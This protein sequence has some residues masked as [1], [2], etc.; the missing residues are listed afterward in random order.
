M[1][2][3]EEENNTWSNKMSTTIGNAYVQILPT[4]KGI[5]G[6]LE[7]QLNPQMTKAGVSGGKSFGGGL[8]SS[9]KGGAIFAG[10]TVAVAG[11]TK[12]I[13]DSVKEGAAL[14]QSLG[15]I[16]KLYGEHSDTM[17]EQANKAYK[18]V[19]MSANQ[20]METSMQ[21]SASLLQGLG[22]DTKKAARITDMA[23]R[24]MAD[25][26]NTFGSTQESVT[27]AYRG[28]AKQNYTMLD[29]LKLGYGGTKTEM[30]RLL[31]DAE[32]LTGKKYDINNLSDVYEAIHAIQG[33]LKVTGTTSKEALGTLSGSFMA[34]KANWSNV[35]GHLALGDNKQLLQDMGNLFESIKGMTKNLVPMIG[36]ILAGLVTVVIPA[37]FMGILEG[38]QSSFVMLWGQ[39]VQGLARLWAGIKAEC[40]LS[41][42]QLKTAIMSRIQTIVASVR[43]VFERAKNA[44]ITPINKAKNL[45]EKAI[46]TIKGFF[47]NLRLKIP[48]PKLPKLPK[49]GLNWGTKSVLG[50]TIKFPA[51]ISVKG[52]YAKG[53]IFDSASI[54]GVGEAGTEAV[55]PLDR[56]QSLLDMNKDTV[57]LNRIVQRLDRVIET[58]EEG[59]IIRINNREFGR[60]VNGV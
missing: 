2:R 48:T 19:G 39:V 1:E 25:N 16:Q 5:K 55:M 32:K 26:W 18:T 54:I 30:E 44:M 33:K 42:N 41:W 3:K 49:F 27:D 20:Y 17:I 53:G 50:K 31:R 56:L 28:F 60:L 58:I 10:L 13:K 24:D 29:N 9:L 37:L 6:A 52:W 43:G 45:I 22:G 36:K 14:E 15:G 57:A 46:K 59:K 47:S 23:M 11:V 8:M 51:G 40:I 4:T 21:F 7:R 12:M 35:L 34:L 38:L